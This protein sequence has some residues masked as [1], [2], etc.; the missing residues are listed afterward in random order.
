MDV[1]VSSLA[2]KDAATSNAGLE[3][4]QLLEHFKPVLVLEHQNFVAKHVEPP[5]VQ[6]NKGFQRHM[7]ILPA[8]TKIEMVITE[9]VVAAAIATMIPTLA[10]IL[11]RVKLKFVEI[12][13]I[14]IATTIRAIFV[15][16]QRQLHQRVT[17][18]NVTALLAAWSATTNANAQKSSPVRLLLMF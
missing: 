18:R 12:R 1:T 15:L 11:I 8:A 7:K 3:T 9:L 4:S 16:R 5:N 14:T 2:L 10:T 6:P 17:N 13:L